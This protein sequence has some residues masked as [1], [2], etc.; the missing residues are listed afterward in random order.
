MVT[1]AKAVVI[2]Q[3]ALVGALANK[4]PQYAYVNYMYD[5]T[6]G[7]YPTITGSGMFTTKC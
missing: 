5:K 6:V 7:V 3:T 4:G 1:V 2:P